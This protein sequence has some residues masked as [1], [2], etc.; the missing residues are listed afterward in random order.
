MAGRTYRYFAGTPLYPFGF[1]LSYTTFSY[2]NAHVDHDQI[3]ASDKVNVSVDV[4]NAGAT[5][6]DEVVELYVTRPDVA[7]APIR[8]LAGFTRVHLASGE[9]RTV[10]IPLCDR[11]LSIV[12]ENGKRRIPVGTIEVWIGGG[13]PVAGVGQTPASGA[14]TQFRVT[15]E[16]MLPD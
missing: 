6:G 3:S 2:T 9:Q 13:Q 5:A 12:D 14:R 4:K 15:S 10:S 1:G 8:A 16:A 11:E 7:G